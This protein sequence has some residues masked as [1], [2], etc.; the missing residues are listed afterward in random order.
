MLHNNQPLQA[1]T[2]D[3]AL[4]VPIVFQPKEVG[5][6]RSVHHHLT[7]RYA[8][9]A[10][11]TSRPMV[12]SDKADPIRRRQTTEDRCIDQ[13]D[14]SDPRIKKISCTTDP[15]TNL[16]FVVLHTNYATGQ[17]PNILVLNLR[18]NLPCKMNCHVLEN[19][20]HR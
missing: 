12:F 15:T 18:R 17:T 13:S 5:K 11:L 10:P 16:S 6:V 1:I 4:S 8:I 20:N 2:E 3:L 9:I 7:L 14:C 19:S